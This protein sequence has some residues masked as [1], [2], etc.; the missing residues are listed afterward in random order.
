MITDVATCDI[1][2]HMIYHLIDISFWIGELHSGF[3][4]VAVLPSP[5]T[6]YTIFLIHYGRGEGFRVA[7]YLKTVVEV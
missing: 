3:Q 6:F 5:V 1:V 2:L 7:A 4:D